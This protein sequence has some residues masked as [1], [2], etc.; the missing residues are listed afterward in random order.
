M[1]LRVG[2]AVYSVL[3]ASKSAIKVDDAAVVPQGDAL[4]HISID[5]RMHRWPIRLLPDRA[6]EHWIL[7][8]DR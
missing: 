7:I 6:D 2:H 8:E 3:Q 1:T 5:G 4:L